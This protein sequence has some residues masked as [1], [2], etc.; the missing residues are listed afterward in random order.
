MSDA[1]LFSVGDPVPV[2]PL[3][4]GTPRFQVPDRLQSECLPVALDQ[5]V[6]RD[7]QVRVVWDFVEKVDLAILHAH[8]RAFENRPGRPPICPRVL[9]GL[10]LFATLRGVGSARRLA[11]LCDESIPFRWLCGGISVNYP[12]LADFRS[13]SAELF[14]RVL[15]HHI[16]ALRATGLVTLDHVAHDGVRVR[17][18]AGTGSFR[19]RQSLA[20][21]RQE[22]VDQVAALRA[23]LD[24]NPAAAS[25][26]EK[27]A[28]F[29][30]RS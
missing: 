12:T 29:D 19:S 24:A 13:M 17:A 20:E 15:I 28:R 26:R 18:C 4:P 16:T 30:H 3:A 2:P 6:E 5:L 7:H 1:A 22:A 25:A 11:Q 23:E 10:W 27:G 14:E 21:L 9:R 8:I